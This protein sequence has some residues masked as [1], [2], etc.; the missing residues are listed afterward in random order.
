MAEKTFEAADLTT[1]RGVFSPLVG[2]AAFAFP[3]HHR[4]NM[5][6]RQADQKSPAPVSRPDSE[7]NLSIFPVA[8]N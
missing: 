3:N 2:S 4:G 7:S 8:E 6:L 1:R 5:R